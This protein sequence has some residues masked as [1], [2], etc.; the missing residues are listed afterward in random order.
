[1]RRSMRIIGLAG[2][3]LAAGTGCSPDTFLNSEFLSAL[4]YSQGATLIPG[5]SPEVKVQVEN[6][7]DRVVEALLTVRLA[8]D[9]VQQRTYS[10]PAGAK[11]GEAFFCP[12]SQMTLGDVANTST[13]GAIVRLGNGGAND[14]IVEVE[15][16]G[17]I[18]ES[19]VNYDCGDAVTFSVLP[20]AQTRSGYQIFAFV[21]RSG[22]GSTSSVSP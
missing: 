19:G 3:A 22:T 1:M 21:R 9:N 4:G 5:E 2:L 17:V 13:T 20:S 18:L 11:F 14:P 6:R 16:F 10:I 7:T 8:Q 15:P 12:V